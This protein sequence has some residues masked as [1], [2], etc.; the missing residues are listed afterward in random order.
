MKGNLTEHTN[1]PYAS[2]TCAVYFASE[3]PLHIPS[4]L[5]DENLKQAAQFRDD[6]SSHPLSELWLDEIKLNAGHVISHYLVTGTYQRLQPQEKEY[7]KRVSAE[8]A[9]AIRVYV[10]TD[11]LTL[12]ALREMAR[13]EIVH[14]GEYLNLPALIK[15]MEEAAL[16][17]D[18][19]PGIATY[20]QSRVLSYSQD[21]IIHGS[22]K[23]DET[24]DAVGVPDSL[25][26]VLLRSI[27][28]AKASEDRQKKEPNYQ[29]SGLGYAALELRPTEEAMER[30]EKKALRNAE[31]ACEEEGIQQLKEKKTN[32]R[33]LRP[34]LERLQTLTHNA[35][36]RAQEESMERALDAQRWLYS[37]NSS[38]PHPIPEQGK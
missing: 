24:L 38:I 18:A 27:L 30:T 23:A 15:V 28:L 10:A 36:K 8:L 2:G 4:S 3:G 21:E 20:V 34:D 12:P 11:S 5:L 6:D 16:S 25:S 33:A 22:D 35:E 32:G 14:L 9:T 13:V 31:A 37:R 1:R 29:L 19:N 7:E 26:K 17:F